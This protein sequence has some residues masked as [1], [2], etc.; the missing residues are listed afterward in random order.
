MIPVVPPKSVPKNK[1]EL[2]ADAE[3]F[4][5]A[6]EKQVDLL[7]D[8]GIKIGK[9]AMVIGGVLTAGYLLTTLFTSDSKKSKLPKIQI[10]NEKFPKKIKS[11]SWIVNSIKGYILAFLIGIA[12]EKI[13]EAL[14]NLD[15]DEQKKEDTI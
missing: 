7:K 1:Q 3:K 10:S 13:L 2:K 6:I 4:R 9:T 5:N 12:R 11:D 14:E 8:N 15:K